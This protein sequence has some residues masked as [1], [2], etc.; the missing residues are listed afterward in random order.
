MKHAVD[1][2]FK[3]HSSTGLFTNSFT[4][5]RQNR[6]LVES[7]QTCMRVEQFSKTSM[8]Q[9]WKIER[10]RDCFS[11]KA[12]DDVLNL[13]KTSSYKNEKNTQNKNKE[14]ELSQTDL[15]DIDLDLHDQDIPWLILRYKPPRLELV[16]K[17]RNHKCDY[18]ECGKT[19]TKSSHLKAHIR[20][21]TGE[22][23][24][25]CT[26]TNC[27][28]NFARSDEL[29]RHMRR[30]TGYKPYHCLSC[31]KAFSRCDHLTLHLKQRHK[32]IVNL[33]RKSLRWPSVMLVVLWGRRD[34]GSQKR[35][36]V[37]VIMMI[38]IWLHRKTRQ[39]RR[40]PR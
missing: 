17:P 9:S 3:M 26:W 19:Y 35:L 15:K 34:L 13:E 30:H 24:F 25:K 18:P 5:N 28:W 36:R 38:S 2:F 32:M 14:M 10:L 20:T 16:Q 8:I 7:S 12:A 37:T 21:H 6:Q 27:P 1:L 23:P 39:A 4:S 22:K 29:T 33:K 11:C 40:I 31:H